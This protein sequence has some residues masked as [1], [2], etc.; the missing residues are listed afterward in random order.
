MEEF[1]EIV[2]KDGRVISIAP[3]S[4]IHG[5]PSMLHKVVHVLV[6]NL[7]G[8]LLLQ[9]RASHKDVAPSKWDTSV[10]GHIKPGENILTAAKREM[11]EELGVVPEN[12]RFLYTYIHSNEYESELVYTY[13][14]IHEGPFDFN[15]NEIEEV[16]FWSIEKIQNSLKSGFFSDNFKHE[17]FRFISNYAFMPLCFNYF[18]N[19][20]GPPYL[21]GDPN[22]LKN[23]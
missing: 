19:E 13:W 8:E 4:F 18:L 17:F 7:K 15:K 5:N 20:L 3:R 16:A 6:F 10:G 9:K 2:D 23:F 11:L 21:S 1:L 12:L 22:F 14:T